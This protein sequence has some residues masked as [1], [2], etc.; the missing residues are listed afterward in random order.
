MSRTYRQPRRGGK[1]YAG[2]CRNHGS[3]S[4]CAMGRQH[5]NKRRVPLQEAS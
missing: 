2:E 1:R 4:W 5:K 3:C